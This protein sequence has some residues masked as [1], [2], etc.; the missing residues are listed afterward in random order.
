MYLFCAT[1]KGSA[2]SDTPLKNQFCSVACR[3]GYIIVALG[4]I[5]LDGLT[6]N[7]DVWGQYHESRYTLK[8]VDLSARST[9]V[10]EGLLDP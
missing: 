5:L 4:Y 8:Q 6:D 7:E 1:R 3:A 9:I 2:L 10:R